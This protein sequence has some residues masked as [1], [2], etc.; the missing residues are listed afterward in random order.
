MF[1]LWSRVNETSHIIVWLRS[2][3]ICND[4]NILN[5]HYQ[6]S[7]FLSLELYV[8]NPWLLVCLDAS[9]ASSAT[10]M[11]YMRV[12]RAL[13]CGSG[14]PT[15]F[16]LEQSDTNHDSPDLSWPGTEHR[17]NAKRSG[18]AIEEG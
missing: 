6:L 15:S 10:H 16:N 12:L 13:C 14:C 8:A 18:K 7:S 1:F 5:K 3:I 9:I 11:T 17:L 4:F 2:I